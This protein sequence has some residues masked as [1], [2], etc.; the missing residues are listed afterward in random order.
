MSQEKVTRY[1][2]EKANRKQT[3]KKEKRMRILRTSVVS[4]VC[5]AVIGWVGYSAVATY[6]NS[7]PRETAEVDYTAVTEYMNGLN[8]DAQ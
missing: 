3:M 1:K 7:I 5:V 6:I 2:E 8:A 4:V